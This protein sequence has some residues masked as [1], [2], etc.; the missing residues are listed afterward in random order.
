MTQSGVLVGDT[1]ILDI[2][3][4]TLD[5]LKMVYGNFNSE[6]LDHATWENGGLNAH[7]REPVLRA[8]KQLGRT[9]AI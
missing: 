8:V 7:L 9:L 2:G 3:A 4:Y 1:I 6:G 5:A